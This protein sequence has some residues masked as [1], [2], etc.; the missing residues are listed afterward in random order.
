MTVRITMSH[1]S[2][3][4]RTLK[5][6][7]VSPEAAVEAVEGIGERGG[8]GEYVEAV[9]AK[10]AVRYQ[11]AEWD[12]K[13]WVNEIES[14]DID[15]DDFDSGIGVFEHWLTNE[16]G[17]TELGDFFNIL[18]ERQ[19]SGY[20]VHYDKRVSV[21]IDPAMAS[22]NNL[23]DTSD[24]ESYVEENYYDLDEDDQNDISDIDVNEDGTE[25]VEIEWTG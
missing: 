15:S 11:P 3:F 24:V 16:E 20:T 10:E 14:V 22:E 19:A 1:P 21:Y 18:V 13:P 8:I 6:A 17:S 23:T 4:I 5:K 12:Y 25:W 7:A 9:E 2:L